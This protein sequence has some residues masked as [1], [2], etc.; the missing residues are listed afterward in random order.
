ML[1]IS[2]EL[3]ESTFPNRLQANTWKKLSAGLS[4]SSLNNCFN[5]C[6]IREPWAAFALYNSLTRN[7]RFGASMPGR[8]QSTRKQGTPRATD[9]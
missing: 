7:R 8:H 9:S 5:M 3:L 2:I 1:Q 4:T 6:S